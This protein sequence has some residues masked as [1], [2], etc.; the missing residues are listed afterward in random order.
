MPSFVLSPHPYTH[1]EAIRH[2][3]VDAQFKGAELTLCYALQGDIAALALPQPG[4]PQRA[5]GLWQHTCFEAFLKWRPGAA[6]YLEFNFA[7]SGAWAAY[8]FQAYREGMAP[9]ALAAPSIDLRSGA[10]WLELAVRILFDAC[11]APDAEPRL[12]LSA[13]IEEPAGRL[14]YWACAHPPG[15]PDFHHP[16]NFVCLP[17]QG[18]GGPA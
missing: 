12:A 6:D 10:D 18:G 8:R 16:G 1:C 5:D 9:A 14:S 13:V 11:P 3:Q 15:K 4:P 17:G 2:V 7:P